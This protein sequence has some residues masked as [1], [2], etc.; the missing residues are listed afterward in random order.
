MSQLQHPLRQPGPT[1]DLPRQAH[2]QLV[3]T[4]DAILPPPLADTPE[5]LLARTDAAILKIGDLLPTNTNEAD[6]AAQ[7]VA[8]RAQAEEIMRLTREHA[9][10]I[11]VV[12]KLNAQYIAMV[13]T[14]LSAYAHLLRAQARRHKREQNN[15]ALKADEWTQHIVVSRMN[16]AL[17]AGPAP[18]MQPPAHT[19]SA[20]PPLEPAPRPAAPATD[21]PAPAPTADPSAKQA[22]HP[23]ASP[24]P[25]PVGSR[26]HRHVE[27][28]LP[29]IDEP[30]RNLAAEADYYAN[31]Y[32]QRAR[33][34][35]RYGA[36][37]PDCDF[38]PPDDNLVRMVATG[39]SAALRA[40]DPP[41]AAT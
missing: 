24:P 22:A 8:A 37:P 11:K 33:L 5:A 34:I 12:T 26:P 16:Q 28:T 13:R 30:P 21:Q 35:R 27:P 3:H 14:S 40:L 23:P 19:L 32:P 17:K 1:L 10:D 39:T 6:L 4:L 18:A 7:C 38:G 36:L 15:D 2:Y 20:E 41:G 25:S 31:V 9:G 29:E